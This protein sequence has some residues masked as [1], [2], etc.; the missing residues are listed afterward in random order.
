MGDFSFSPQKWTLKI[1]WEPTTEIFLIQSDL[2]Q[3]RYSREEYFFS[4][5]LGV[6]SWDVSEEMRVFGEQVGGQIRKNTPENVGK[7]SYKNE[8]VRSAKS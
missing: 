8:F 4:L 5:G 7:Q 2:Q 3:D 6:L 1:L